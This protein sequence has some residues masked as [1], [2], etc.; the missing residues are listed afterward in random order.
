MEAM[1]SSCLLRLKRSRR[2]SWPWIPKTLL[3]FGL[4]E[5]D[6]YIWGRMGV[7]SQSGYGKQIS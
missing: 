2:V 5:G 4:E 3:H 1:Y 7:F 6:T